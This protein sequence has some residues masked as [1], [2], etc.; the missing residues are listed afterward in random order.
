M[1][2]KIKAIARRVLLT[3]YL[4]GT[5]LVTGCDMTDGLVPT[6]T[7]T[8]L[9]NPS[10]EPISPLEQTTAY[11]QLPDV[12]LTVQTA[13]VSDPS[14]PDAHVVPDL[15]PAGSHVHVLAMDTNAAWLLVL[16]RG[17][18]GWVPSFYSGTAIGTMSLVTLEPPHT[19]ACGFM[20]A[21]LT[22]QEE[23]VG[24]MTGSTTIQGI[25]YLPQTPAP[26]A[27]GPPM[28]SL[29]GAGKIAGSEATH[30]DLPGS[31]T[32]LLFGFALAELQ[33]GSRVHF[34][35]EGFESDLIAFQAAFLQGD[36]PIQTNAS[37]PPVRT[38]TGPQYPT[39]SDW[40]IRLYNTD[41]HGLAGLNGAIITE[42]N[43]EEDSG[44]VDIS[45][46]MLPGDNILYFGTWNEGSGYTW[47]FSVSYNGQLVW[48]NTQGQKG[49][50]GAYNDDKSR[51]MQTVY[52][53]TLVLHPDGST[54]ELSANQGVDGS[55]IPIGLGDRVE[56]TALGLAVHSRPRID[57]K[58]QIGVAQQ[59]T[60][61][62]VV[63]GPVVLPTTS[64]SNE[65]MLR[66][67]WLV[68]GWDSSGASGWCSAR[69]LQVVP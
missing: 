19:Q 57:R 27:P 47:G 31:G 56:V 39:Q 68:T 12:E 20:G 2:K 53:Q 26:P 46:Q 65:P 25:V 67:W 61:L 62:Q 1:S 37:S 55:S 43:F 34:Q 45:D 13:L 16:Y 36:C 6:P 64:D 41:D 60:R 66:N 24:Q 21:T 15:I 48:D 51:P 9:K 33:P 8:V 49:V 3:G 44:W 30:L 38:A 69:Y 50:T 63:G 4:L 42:T 28:L 54:E 7:P 22:P 58:T 23:W 17:V 52:G 11:Q 59:G 18:L 32:L 14:H 5:L 35:G 10:P 40:S 29:E